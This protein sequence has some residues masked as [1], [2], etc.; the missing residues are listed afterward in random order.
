[1]RKIGKSSHENLL[2]NTQRLVS[3]SDWHVTLKHI[4]FLP[5]G[6]I[7]TQS[8]TYKTLINDADSINSVSFFLEKI[9]ENRTC[10]DINIQKDACSCST[11][12]E[13][14]YIVLKSGVLESIQLLMIK[15]NEFMDIS[16]EIN[17][18]TITIKEMISPEQIILSEINDEYNLNNIIMT[19]KEIQDTRLE[20]ILSA[21]EVKDFGST[22]S[23]IPNRTI[24]IQNKH[25]NIQVKSIR[26]LDNIQC[27]YANSLFTILTE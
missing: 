12:K 19:I 4:A 7:D 27:D 16:N 1:M 15:I 18:N 2:E 24:K 23:L 17:C 26:I 6:N 13:L 14:E 5:Y 3:R 21:S 10:E 22:M 9:P 25:I 20:F 11:I 8:N